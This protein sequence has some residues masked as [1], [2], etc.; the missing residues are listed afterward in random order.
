VPSEVDDDVVAALE[1]AHD[2]GDE[3]A[4]AVLELVEDDVALGVAHALDD[5]LL[6]GLR[7]DAAEALA[8]LLH[9]EHVAEVAVLLARLV[10]SSGLEVEDLEAELLAELRLEAVTAR[11]LDRDLALRVVHL[12]DD[13]H[14]LEEVDVARVAVEARL[15]LAVGA[16]GRLAAVRIACSMVS[17]R[18]LAS[19]PFSLADLLDDGVE[20]NARALHD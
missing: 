15:E 14:V 5:H 20:R 4:L 2:A 17:T 11:V 13:R 6:G 16:E 18:T 19:M 7:R 10:A 8:V 1:A 9:L 12:L 3:L